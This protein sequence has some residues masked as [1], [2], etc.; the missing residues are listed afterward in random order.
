MSNLIAIAY[1]SLETAQT[2]TSSPGR[3]P[4]SCW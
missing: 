3:R 4:C 2:V 1:D